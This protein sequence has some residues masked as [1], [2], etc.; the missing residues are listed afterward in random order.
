MNEVSAAI[1]I[2]QLKKINLFISKRNSNAAILRDKLSG[3]KK[4]YVLPGEEGKSISSN[5]CVNIVLNDGGENIR[6]SLILELQKNNIGTSVHYP[7]CLPKSIYYKNLGNE[8]NYSV[9]EHYAA[10]TISLP[11]G[12]H[13]GSE[14]ANLIADIFIKCLER[15]L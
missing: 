6:N 8:E 9:A 14:E 15:I 13:L 11:C 4:I 3:N 5:F 12:P 7:V 10:H 2:E 1:G